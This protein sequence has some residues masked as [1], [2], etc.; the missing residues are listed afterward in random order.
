MSRGGVP[1]LG[2][3]GQR[4]GEFLSFVLAKIT[5]C[6]MIHSCVCVHA[7]LC[8]LYAFMYISF[9]ESYVLTS[10]TFSEIR[11]IKLEIS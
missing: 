1:N 4:G 7:H 6:Y 11:R 3:N 8:M 2:S 10:G 9:S 5:C